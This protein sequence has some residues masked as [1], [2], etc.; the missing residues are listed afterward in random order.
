MY[1]AHEQNGE[2]N[3]EGEWHVVGDEDLE[4]SDDDLLGS[5]IES[6]S[7]EDGDDDDDGLDFG[8]SSGDDWEYDEQGQAW[9]EAGMPVL[10]PGQAS[11][12]CAQHCHI[13]THAQ[14]Y[15]WAYVGT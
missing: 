14:L 9:D 2:W 3:D 10:M 13:H 6:S 1:G 12:C 8:D 15:E 11:P 4:S 5:D 7:D